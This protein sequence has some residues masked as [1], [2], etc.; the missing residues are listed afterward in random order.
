MEQP[1][2]SG[3]KE[4]DCRARADEVVVEQRGVCRKLPAQ[5]VPVSVA[6]GRSGVTEIAASPRL[7]DSGGVQEAVDVKPP[8]Q[9]MPPARIE[10]AH[11]V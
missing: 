3:R 9:E 4:D 1:G 7:A 2:V 10:L 5:P 6:D 11:A 8:V